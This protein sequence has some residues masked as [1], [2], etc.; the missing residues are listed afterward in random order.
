MGRLTANKCDLPA[1]SCFGLPVLY[2]HEDTATGLCFVRR[3]PRSAPKMALLDLIDELLVWSFKGLDVADDLVRLSMSCKKLAALTS[4]SRVLWLNIVFSSAGSGRITDSQLAAFLKRVDARS[5]TALL[6]LQYCKISGVGL[7]PL[8]GS[9]VLQFLDL[10][11]A[12]GPSAHYPDR[13]KYWDGEAL[14]KLLESLQLSKPA[15]GHGGKHGKHGKHVFVPLQMKPDSVG[16]PWIDLVGDEAVT[17][18]I[19]AALISLIVMGSLCSACKDDKDDQEDDD[20]QGDL[21]D[22]NQLPECSVCRSKHCEKCSTSSFYLC[23]GCSLTVCEACESDLP[24]AEVCANDSCPNWLCD[25]CE[26]DA[27]QTCAACDEKFCE[28]CGEDGDE[29]PDGEFHCRAC[30]EAYWD[31]LEE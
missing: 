24:K 17:D 10:R 29:A 16:H 15:D 21:V 14:L 18:R 4:S 3:P 8:Q 26:T 20:D 25:V 1:F 6:R 11:Q 22:V 19:R 30:A 5:C 13:R 12:H 23:A 28:E 7:L 31:E 27:L 2:F 9:E